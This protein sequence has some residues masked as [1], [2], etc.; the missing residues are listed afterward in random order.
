MEV[1]SY[2]SSWQLATTCH[3]INMESQEFLG[4]QGSKY[5]EIPHV[6]QAN[7]HANDHNDLLRTMPPVVQVA[8]SQPS[9]FHIALPPALLVQVLNQRPPLTSLTS[10]RL[11]LGKCLNWGES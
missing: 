7:Q 5:I 4:S 11:E 3:D 9:T 10:V 2:G 8:K 6:Q 1:S